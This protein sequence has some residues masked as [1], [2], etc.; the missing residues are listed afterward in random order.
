MASDSLM[1]GG[2]NSSAPE[3]RKI[4]CAAIEDVA[5]VLA[6][7]GDVEQ[8]DQNALG[9]DADGV[10]EISGDA[11]ASEDGGDVGAVDL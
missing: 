3:V 1:S 8:A 5:V 6:A 10:V 2:R 9:T 11:L 4:S 7:S